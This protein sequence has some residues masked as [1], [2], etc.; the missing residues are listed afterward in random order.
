LKTKAIPVP[1]ERVGNSSG[2]H[3]GIPRKRGASWIPA[4]EEMSGV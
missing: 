1:R 4:Y 3:T 2:S